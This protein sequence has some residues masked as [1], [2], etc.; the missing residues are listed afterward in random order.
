MNSTKLQTI[1][2]FMVENAINTCYIDSLL[3][4]LFLSPSVISNLL[5]S[6]PKTV[7]AIYLQEYIAS[8]F[9]ECIRNNKS[10]LEET[11]SMIRTLCIDN[12]WMAE[13]SKK[14]SDNYNDEY[15]EQ[16]DISEFYTFILNLLSGPVI[17]ITRSMITESDYQSS[18]TSEEKIPFIPLSPIP[19]PTQSGASSSSS[20]EGV[21]VKDMLTSWMYDNCLNTKDKKG[22]NTYNIVNTP[23]IMCMS[24]NR[25]PNGKDR[26]NTDVIIQKKINPLMNY[27]LPFQYEWQFHAVICHVGTTPKSGHYYTLLQHDKKYYIFDDMKVPSIYEVD[28]ADQTITNKVKKDCVFLI[29]KYV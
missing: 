5:T 22:L 17:D 6:D 14:K 24:I 12:G 7:N 25:F 15:I 10:V 20:S 4:G 29:Y 9:V 18:T 3:V 21:T 1:E 27:T 11:V 26:D 13:K 19:K 2:P 16:Q 23:Y 8:N 28:M